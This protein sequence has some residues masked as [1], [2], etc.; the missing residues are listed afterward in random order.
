MAQ[1][2][3]AVELYLLAKCWQNF[4][5]VHWTAG[6]IRW[7]VKTCQLLSFIITITILQMP[8]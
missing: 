3:D 8:L 1:I 7:A 6:T 5:A 4:V 2:G